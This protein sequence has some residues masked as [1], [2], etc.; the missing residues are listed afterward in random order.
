[1][2]NPGPSKPTSIA[3]ALDPQIGKR[4]E[5]V[6]VEQQAKIEIPPMAIVGTSGL[7]HASGFINEEQLAQLRYLQGVQY[8]KQMWD[9]SAVVGSIMFIIMA[10]LRQAKWTVK[11]Q[12]DKSAATA[13]SEFLEECM[14]DME[15]SWGSFVSEVISMLVF[16]FSYFETVMKLRK[17]EH[18]DDPMINSQY[19]DG[20]F[21]LRSLEIRSQD[22]VYQWGLS[23]RGEILG[24]VQMDYWNL[25]GR[26]PVFLPM[27]KCLHFTTR[28]YKN[29]PEGYSLLRPVVRAYHYV[30]RLEEIEA[31]SMDR[32]LSGMPVMEVPPQIMLKDAS[33]GERTLFNTLQQ[34][35]QQIKVD[36][37]WGA[38]IPASMDNDNKPTGFKF[39]LLSAGGTGSRQSIN[40]AITRYNVQVM[41]A[42]GA[43]FIQIGQS[44]VGTTSLFEGK[45]NLFLMGL[46]H[47][48][49]IITETLNRKLVPMLMRLN[50]VPR[51]L[52]PE[53][54]HGKLDKPDLDALGTFLQKVG[55]AGILS[56]NRQLEEKVLELAD[57]PV[58]EDED[59]A[60]FDDPTKPTPSTSA[61]R[62]SGLLSDEQ[63]KAAMDINAA[64]A[65]KK[66]SF[67]AAKKLL[68]ARLGMDP[69]HAQEFLEQV[70]EKEPSQE[71]QP[72]LPGQ[73]PIPPGGGAQP[74]AG[75][76][77]PPQPKPEA[78]P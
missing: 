75:L 50:G 42:F 48:L 58:P 33:E 35:I 57:L 56:P 65:G 1:M 7:R 47:Y 59:L 28:S 71:T 54:E 66:M 30:K 31:I 10:V 44:K 5:L 64:V 51:E 61:D 52:W 12:S 68:G 24:L 46:T 14:L 13:E 49:D 76:A 26:G 69:E 36:E 78:Q 3:E 43:D 39:S 20:R 4:P 60:I 19:S 40:E 8:Y 55:A 18:L 45:S 70:E 6:F 67:N 53:F 2:K 11:S 15:H 27:S 63:V 29:S 9:D 41:Q 37:R 72:V 21:G 74:A 62:A 34:M 22:T 17:G 23:R 25:L 77:V 38:V 73:K 32:N 16:G